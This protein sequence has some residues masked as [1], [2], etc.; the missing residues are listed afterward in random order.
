MSQKHVVHQG[1]THPWVPHFQYV[2]AR[3][4]ALRTGTVQANWTQM[5]EILTK[6]GWPNRR[7]YSAG[8]TENPGFWYPQ[9]CQKL[10]RRY[11]KY[12]GVEDV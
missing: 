4:Y 10:Y 7:A 11:C 1:D 8:D 12:N 5:A 9:E 2:G 6:E 3:A